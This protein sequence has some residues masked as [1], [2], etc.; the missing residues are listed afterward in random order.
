MP[1]CHIP[2]FLDSGRA[3]ENS[4]PPLVM[5]VCKRWR[6]IAEEMPGLWDTLAINSSQGMAHTLLRWYQCMAF[7]CEET[8]PLFIADHAGLKA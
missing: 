2:T 7:P 1:D 4:A 5:R 6:A 3:S 8:T